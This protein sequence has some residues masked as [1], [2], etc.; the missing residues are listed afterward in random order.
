MYLVLIKMVP[1]I[2]QE[3]FLLKQERNGNRKVCKYTEGEETRLI[4]I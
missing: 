3:L 1:N 2:V 4:S